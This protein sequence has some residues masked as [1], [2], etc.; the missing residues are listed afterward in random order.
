[1][2]WQDIKWQSTQAHIRAEDVVKRIG[3]QEHGMI[4]LMLKE[5]YLN[6]INPEAAESEEEQ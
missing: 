5:S 4:I 2:L 1:M 3:K 6:L